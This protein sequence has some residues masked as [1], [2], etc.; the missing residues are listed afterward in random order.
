MD[1]GKWDEEQMK[2]RGGGRGFLG[3]FG[4][5]RSEGAMVGRS[6]GQQQG[7][8][9]IRRRLN[10]EDLGDIF[11]GISSVMRTKIVAVVGNTPKEM[12]VA[13][14]DGLEVMA[15]AVEDLMGRITE[16]DRR[17]S[18]ERKLK[19]RRAAE[20][21]ARLEEKIQEM[22]KRAEAALA[23]A[24]KGVQE[25]EKK[26]EVGLSKVK[27]VEERLSERFES[28]QGKV[29]DMEERA[30]EERGKISDKVKAVSDIVDMAV[31]EVVKSRV[32]ESVKEMEGKVRVA[33]CGVKV[34]NFNIGQETDNK[35]LIVR[36]VLGVVR[37]AARREEE[38]Q[39]DKVL[40]RTRVVV[41][42]KRT[43]GRREGVETIQS[44]PILL[45]CQ[46]RKDAQVLEGIL[47][48][49]GYFPTLHWPDEVMGF[50]MGVREEVRRRGVSGMESWIRIRP[51]EEEG[52]VRIRVDTKS[53]TG[54]KFRLEGVWGCPPL[55]QGYW[56]EVEGLYTP[57]YVG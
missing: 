20:C 34:S 27:E 25:L 14:K 9:S 13:M 16:K 41:L 28:V 5:G 6:P 35:V 22:E 47:K 56:D 10:D 46:D 7:I 49:A 54:G 36:K 38:G 24:E 21:M 43:E 8:R 3:K 30:M 15:K 51:V 32:K 1:G 55:T 17:E 40:R 23:K 19:E 33:M 39:L 31:D 53:K 57:L 11:S 42:G 26:A 12:Q 2:G 4:R 18:N 45:Q 48:G 29:T 44:V 50:I 37:K 52:R